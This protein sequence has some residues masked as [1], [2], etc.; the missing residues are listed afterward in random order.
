MGH[1]TVQAK[2]FQSIP[3]GLSILTMTS[4]P[5][6][7]SLLLHQTE[8]LVEPIVCTDRS[9]VVVGTSTGSRNAPVGGDELNIQV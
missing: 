5:R 7:K 9:S 1:Q 6:F 8:G 3:E 4:P 2:S